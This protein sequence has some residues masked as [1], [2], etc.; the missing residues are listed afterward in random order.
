MLVTGGSGQLGRALVAKL[1]AQGHDVLAPPR[2]RFDLLA[3]ESALP[4]LPWI[5]DALVNAAAM[6]DVDG[7]ELDPDTAEAVNARSPGILAQFCRTH[8]VRFI[9]ISTDYVFDGA[10][11]GGYVETDVTAPLQVYGRT[12]RLGEA[13]ALSA[14]PETLVVRTAWLFGGGGSSDLRERMRAMFRSW[15]ERRAREGASAPLRF[16]TD[17]RSSPTHVG[18]LAAGLTELLDTGAHGVMHLVNPGSTSRFELAQALSPPPGSLEPGRADDFPRPA[19]RP[20]QSAL[21]TVRPDT[22]RLRPGLVAW[23]EP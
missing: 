10:R 19:R 15:E 16:A 12:K 20:A 9:H 21:R 3:V 22:P 5:P 18:D 2:S 14:L 6:T 17:Q 23:C 11:A 7:C 4:S 1:A 8:R 13:A